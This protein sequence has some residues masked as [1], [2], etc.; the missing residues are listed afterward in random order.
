MLRILLVCAG[1]M[2][3]SLVTKALIKAGKERGIEIESDA[4]GLAEFPDF[5]R[6]NKWDGLLVAPQ[7]KHNFETFKKHA[8]EL[9]IP[10]VAIKP[11]AYTPLGG[12]FLMTHL[13]EMKLID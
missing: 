3:S 8:D 11:Q 6:A 12:D 1:G 4:T 7:M 9:G 13:K 2:S 10:I 5:V